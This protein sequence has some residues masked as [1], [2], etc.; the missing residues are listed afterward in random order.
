LF[1]GTETCPY[2][3]KKR[4]SLDT[5]PVILVMFPPVILSEGGGGG[6]CA[7]ALEIPVVSKNPVVDNAIV[8]PMTANAVNTTKIARFVLD[9]MFKDH[10]KLKRI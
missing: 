10:K 9:D 2:K 4:V 3:K 1:F 8:A 5:Y 7:Y 6:A